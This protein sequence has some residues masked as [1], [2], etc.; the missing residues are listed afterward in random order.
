MNVLPKNKTDHLFESELRVSY[1]FFFFFSTRF[2][3][4]FFG[5][6]KSGPSLRQNEAPG[7]E[8]MKGGPSKRS[9]QWV[10]GVLLEGGVAEWW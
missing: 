7:E 4:H 10:S 8:C 6:C 1:L 3:F 5:K 9:P 2:V